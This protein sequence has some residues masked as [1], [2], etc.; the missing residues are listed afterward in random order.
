[1]EIWKTLLSVI[2]GGATT[3]LASYLLEARKLKN[4]KFKFN[5]E[6]VIAVGEDFYRF[7]AYALIRFE[8]LL[9]NYETLGDYGT[10]EA[11]NLLQ[12][13]DENVQQLLAKIGEN[14]IT[15]TMA[16]LFYD[17][18]GA[19][20]ATALIQSMKTG[21]AQIEEIV[22]TGGNYNDLE[23]PLE[24]V[25]EI[26]RDYIALIKGDRLKIGNKLKELLIVND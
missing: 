19:E 11:R 16:D 25:K 10:Q 4:E 3:F 18:S 15:I 2:V 17:V 1:M 24:E 14:N 6:K 22:A 13:T 5:R 26:L 21:Q 9:H 8:N 20:K 23:T 7:S 12:R